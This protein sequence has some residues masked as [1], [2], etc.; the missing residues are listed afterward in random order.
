MFKRRRF[1]QLLTLQDRLGA[2]SKQVA[3]QAAALNPGPQRD[4]LLRK[5]RQADV[6]TNLDN[7]AKSPGLQPPN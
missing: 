7:W 6:A 2:W 3:E 4:A 5:A 1:K